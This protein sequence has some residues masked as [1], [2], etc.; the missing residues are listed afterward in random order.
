MLPLHLVAAGPQG[1]AE[2]QSLYRHEA[3]VVGLHASLALRLAPH[4]VRANA[5]C[6][7]V[8][9]TPMLEA[10]LPGMAAPPE[11]AMKRFRATIPLGRMPEAGRRGERRAFFRIPTRHA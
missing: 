10:F 11:E 8:V 5:I 9:A 1:K 4:N 7:T 3:R 6:P 2:F